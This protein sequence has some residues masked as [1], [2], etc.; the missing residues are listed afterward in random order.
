MPYINI[1]L[2]CLLVSYSPWQTYLWTVFSWSPIPLG[3]ALHKHIFNLPCTCL[4]TGQAQHKQISN[5]PCSRFPTGQTLHKHTS[6][7]TSPGVCF[8]IDHA[9]HKHITCLTPAGSPD[10]LVSISSQSSA[11]QSYHH[12]PPCVHHCPPCLMLLICGQN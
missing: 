9:L 11:L 6:S 10:A 2:I 7:L 5:F 4:P 8:S 12:C 1:S 3:Q